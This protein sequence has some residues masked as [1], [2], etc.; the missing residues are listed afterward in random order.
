MAEELLL[1]VSPHFS[2]FLPPTIPDWQFS[3]WHSFS[4]CLLPSALPPH[5]SL[6]YPSCLISCPPHASALTWWWW[7]WRREGDIKGSLCVCVS[8]RLLLM[9]W[10][11]PL[12]YFQRWKSQSWKRSDTTATYSFSERSDLPWEESSFDFHLLFPSETLG[13]LCLFNAGVGCLLIESGVNYDT[14][15]QFI[16]AKWLR[17]QVLGATSVDQM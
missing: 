1:Q 17:Y 15:R 5:Q 6:H 2:L 9:P 10:E 11:T 8:I 4:I 7:Q 16:S 14:I 3:P 12:A 13:R